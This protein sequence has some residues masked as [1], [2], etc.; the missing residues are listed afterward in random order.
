MRMNSGVQLTRT[1]LGS[2]TEE[3]TPL[4]QKQETICL[5]NVQHTPM[6]GR[7]QPD[8]VLD[9]RRV[10]PNLCYAVGVV[11]V[12]MRELLALIAPEPEREPVFLVD[13]GAHRSIACVSGA[14]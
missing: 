8:A 5:Y 14:A 4:L 12:Y 7:T 13:I 1:A 2:G 10:K 3:L 11:N 9:Q 6:L